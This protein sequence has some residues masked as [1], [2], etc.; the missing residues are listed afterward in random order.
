MTTRAL[1]DHLVQV[2]S[3]EAILGFVRSDWNGYSA[4]RGSHLASATLLGTYA[5]R[6]LA[7]EALRQRPR[8]I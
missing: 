1:T 2:S 7:Q 4:L 3:D 5:T 6:G 8:S